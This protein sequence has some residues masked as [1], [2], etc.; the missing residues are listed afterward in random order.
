MLLKQNSTASV[1]GFA[2]YSRK[3]EIEPAELV[4]AAR[5]WQKSYL[6][7]QDGILMHAFVGNLAGEFADVILASDAAAFANMSQNFSN[8]ESSRTFHS[9]LDE[10]TIKLTQIRLL[11]NA[12]Q[13]PTGFSSIEI[14]KLALR[15]V[16]GEEEMLASAAQLKSNYLSRFPEAKAHVMGHINGDN[17]AEVAF[18]ENIGAGREICYGYL[19][20]ESGQNFLKHFDQT[21]FDL[22][23]WFVLA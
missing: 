3:P 4:A 5:N 15:G 18:A 11:D 22:D 23:F 17:Y 2:R 13:V 8:D 10:R 20:D 14:G 21:S 16:D 19:Q 7:K 12:F 1:M 9:M 6:A